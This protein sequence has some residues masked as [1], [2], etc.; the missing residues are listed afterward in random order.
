VAKAGTRLN[1]YHI[2]LAAALG[3]SELT[4]YVKPRIAILATGNE[5]ALVG[6]K[7]AENQIFDS[8]KCM[9]SAMC[10]ELGAETVNFGIA[11][12]NLEEIMAKIKQALQNVDALIT[13]GG[14]SVGGLDLVPEAINKLGKPG[15]VTHGMAL[16][17][18]MPTGS[19][20]FRRQAPDG[21]VWKS[22]CGCCW[23]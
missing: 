4:V 21:F 14:T 12:D 18:A 23:V 5:I 20:S 19:C 2:G 15:V 1:P 11:K 22:C 8:N 9:L 7:P 13:T 6:T 17:P 10:H 16:R 3:Y